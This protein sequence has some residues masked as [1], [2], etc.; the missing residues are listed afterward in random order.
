L[1][2]IGLTLDISNAVISILKNQEL[3][4]IEKNLLKQRLA[5][6]STVQGAYME[7]QKSVN[8]NIINTTL[9]LTVIAKFKVI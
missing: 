2:P 5:N 1:V 3:D 8:K 9:M 6:K 7:K 4:P